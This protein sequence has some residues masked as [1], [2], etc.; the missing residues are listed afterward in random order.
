MINKEYIINVNGNLFPVFKNPT[1]EQYNS[2]ILR[3][4]E[5]YPFCPAGEPKTR[6]TFDKDNNIYMWMSGDAMHYIVESFLLRHDN[7]VCN[8]NR[9]FDIA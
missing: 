9:Y 4:K 3:F 7:I 5:L 2:L 8:Q 1:D 6:Q